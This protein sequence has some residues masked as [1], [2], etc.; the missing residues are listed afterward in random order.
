MMLG[1]RNIASLSFHQRL[2]GSARQIGGL[3]AAAMVALDTAK[4]K[5][6]RDH[7]HAT[8]IAKGKGGDSQCVMLSK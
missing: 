8:M 7:E 4:V 3:A 1:H 5:M 2:G 6:A